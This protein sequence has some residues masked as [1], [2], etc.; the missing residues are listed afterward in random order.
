MDDVIKSPAS[1]SW[2]RRKDNLVMRM[3]VG[4]WSNT[5]LSFPLSQV[6]EIH[7]I[8]EIFLK[9]GDPIQHVSVSP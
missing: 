7:R 9:G 6:E 5:E 2:Q 4:S 8:T 3:Q 1:V